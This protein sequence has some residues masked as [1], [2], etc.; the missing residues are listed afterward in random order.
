MDN[1]NLPDDVQVQRLCLTLIGEE[2]L[3]YESMKPIENN[4]QELQ[5][6]FRQQYCKIGNMREQLF[7]VW[8]SFHY[9]ENVETVDAYITCIRH[10]ALLLDYGEPQILDVLKNALPNRLYWVLFSIEDLHQ[11]VETAK[12]V[13]MKEKIDRQLSG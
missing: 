4:W 6:Q 13:L 11:A 2:I 9:D 7:H 10:V 1:H 3:W 5:D 8:R 12:R